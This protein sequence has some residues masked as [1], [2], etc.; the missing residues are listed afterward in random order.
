M[1]K[2]EII[3]NGMAAAVEIESSS[4]NNVSGAN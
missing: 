1:A 3:I 2:I 4:I